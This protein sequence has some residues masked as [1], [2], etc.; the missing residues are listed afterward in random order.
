MLVAHRGPDDCGTWVDPNAGIGL[1]HQRLSIVDL[2]P[3]GHQPMVSSNGRW[4]L[5]YNGEIYNHRHL[6]AELEAA[7]LVPQR[8]VARPFRHRD[9]CRGDR[10]LGTRSSP[11]LERPEC[12]RSACGIAPSGSSTS[13]VTASVRSRSITAGSAAISRSRRSSRRSPLIRASTMISAT[14]RSRLSLRGPTCPRRFRSTAASS[15]C[16]RV[17]FLRS[18]RMRR[19][20]RWTTVRLKACSRWQSSPPPLLVIWRSSGRGHARSDRR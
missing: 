2:S 3:L 6:R 1:G 10:R 9:V 17:A 8:R 14:K 16:S 4:V 5:T 19:H 12:S 15:S 7:G 13:S 18:A 20:R 11:C